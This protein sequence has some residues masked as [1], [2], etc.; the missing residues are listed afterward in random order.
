TSVDN[1]PL[2]LEKTLTRAQFNQL[3]NDLVERTKQPVLNA[4]KDA[5]LSFSDID[6]VI[7]NGGSTRIPA[8]QEMVKSLTGKEPNHS[9]N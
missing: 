6:E 2:H 4:L 5:E 7:L 8:V 3:T 1:G 9:I